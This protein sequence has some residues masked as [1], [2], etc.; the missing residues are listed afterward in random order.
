M[1]PL[2][3]VVSVSTLHAT[4]LTALDLLINLFSSSRAFHGDAVDARLRLQLNRFRLE[5]WGQTWTLDKSFLGEDDERYS[6][7]GHKGWSSIY[8]SLAQILSSIRQASHELESSQSNRAKQRMKS[9]RKKFRRRSAVADSRLLE[10]LTVI[11]EQIGNLLKLSELQFQ[12]QHPSAASRCR[13]R[14]RCSLRPEI[15]EKALDDMANAATLFQCCNAIHS[16]LLFVLSSD[17]HGPV[18]HHNIMDGIDNHKLHMAYRPDLVSMHYEFT[19]TT[20][21][22]DRQGLGDRCSMIK[23][24]ML[25]PSEIQ[26]LPPGQRLDLCLRR[27]STSHLKYT[28]F[29]LEKVTTPSDLVADPVRLYDLIQP[30]NK[31]SRIPPLRSRI[32]LA[33]TLVHFSGRTLSTPLLSALSCSTIR[34]HSPTL[35]DYAPDFVD[36]HNAL[37]SFL[38]RQN[39][40]RLAKVLL[41]LGLWFLLTEHDVTDKDRQAKLLTELTPLMGVDYM[42]ACQACLQLSEQPYQRREAPA[43]YSPS[44]SPD[45]DY[46]KTAR[47]TRL[48]DYESVEILLS[49]QTLVLSPMTNLTDA[50]QRDF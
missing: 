41:E 15:N 8:A 35:H 21:P 30:A 6:I 34:Q 2:D 31:K 12:S 33:G 22:L 9:L 42:R 43:P 44:E 19:V 7:W 16:K 11:D 45:H 17:H 48:A 5:K 18:E 10:A 49:F 29:S 38:M 28:C 36:V 26:L 47:S 1:D 37:G 4:I 13:S 24:D 50:F 40:L 14:K 46:W 23:E 27:E 20:N 32:L 3:S 25:T 39:L